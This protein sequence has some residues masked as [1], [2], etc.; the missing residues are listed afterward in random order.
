MYKA[1]LQNQVLGIDNSFL[2]NEIHNSEELMHSHN[3]DKLYSFQMQRHHL[4]QEH[5]EAIS[6]AELMPP[7]EPKRVS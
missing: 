4:H 2:L 5:P 6:D 7:P 1:L 3:K